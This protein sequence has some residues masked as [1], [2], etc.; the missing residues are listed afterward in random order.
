MSRLINPGAGDYADRLTILALKLLFGE[1]AGKE[2][3]ALKHFRDERN[4]ILAKLALAPPAIES[5]TELGAVNAVLWHA[6]DDLRAHRDTP[7][8]ARAQWTG[9]AGKTFAELVVDLAFRIQAL[10]DRRAQLVAAINQKAGDIRP[11]EQE[12]LP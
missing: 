1:Q 9:F 3:A 4:A 7:I 5:L 11:E 6:E 2:P 10:N 12:K 8:G